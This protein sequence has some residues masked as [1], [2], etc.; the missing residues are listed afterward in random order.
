MQKRKK[1]RRRANPFIESEAG[2]HG[3]SSED[4]SDGNDDL[5]DFIIPDDEEY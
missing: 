5:A 2:V 4:E 1:A 3:E